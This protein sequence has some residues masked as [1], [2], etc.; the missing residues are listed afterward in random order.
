M[1]LNRR[2]A[3]FNRTLANRIVGPTLARLPGFGMIHH[4]GRRSGREYRTPVKIFRHGDD[5]VITLPYGS[6]ADWVKNVLAAGGCE[7]VTGRRRVRL[8]QPR[9]FTDDGSVHIPKILRLALSRMNVTEFF[10]L[11]PD[12]TG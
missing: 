5:Y 4:R 2:F 6:S 10:A 9:L 8:V 1:T 11:A 7:L 3:R 12:R